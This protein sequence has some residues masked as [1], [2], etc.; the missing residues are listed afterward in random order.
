MN[1]KYEQILY[2]K[3]DT[4][5]GPSFNIKKNIQKIIVNFS[6]KKTTRAECSGSCL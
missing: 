1:K 2:R 3:V 4:I 6:L 5:N